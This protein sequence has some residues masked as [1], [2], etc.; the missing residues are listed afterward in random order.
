MDEIE[1]RIYAIA[2]EEVAT[3]HFHPALIAKALAEADGDERKTIARY[4][5]LRVQHLVEEDARANERARQQS[6]TARRAEEQHRAMKRAREQ[7]Q[8]R[9]AALETKGKLFFPPDPRESGEAGCFFC[10]QE[11]AARALWYTEDGAY[12]HIAC[13]QERQRDEARPKEDPL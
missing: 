11:G 1:E 5:K 3:R 7:G 12:A 10:C 9:A 4:I 2:A 8:R 13:I 6:E